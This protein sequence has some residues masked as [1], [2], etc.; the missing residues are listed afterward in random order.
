MDG[1]A[2]AAALRDERPEALPLILTTFGP[3]AYLRRAVEA[4][5]TGF[6]VKDQPAERLA[7]AIRC[8]PAGE[9]VV[10]PEPAAI[11]DGE[12]PLLRASAR[13]SRRAPTAHPSQTSRAP[14]PL[15]GHRSKLPLGGDWQDRR[16]ATE[17]RHCASPATAVGYEHKRIRPVRPA[18]SIGSPQPSDSPS[19][20]AGG[21]SPRFGALNPSAPSTQRRVKGRA[22]DRIP[23]SR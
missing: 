3:P 13:C 4:G 14:L 19:S 15:G 20:E 1:I 5:A 10:D 6:L 17:P 21:E 8:A 2:A 16:P 23:P 12:T 11:E 18:A 9:R 22:F 7:H